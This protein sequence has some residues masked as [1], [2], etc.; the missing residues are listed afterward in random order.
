MVFGYKRNPVDHHPSRIIHIWL[1]K[2]LISKNSEYIWFKNYERNLES[3]F[4]IYVDFEHIL[5][6]EDDAKQNPN[7]SYAN[8]Y[9]KHVACSYGYKLGCVD[10]K[11]SMPLSHI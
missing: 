8:K 6:L 4:M 2:K 7:K 5:G 11:F 10:H 9:Q 3:P 1:N